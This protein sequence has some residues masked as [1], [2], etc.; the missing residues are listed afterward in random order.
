VP[1]APS[2]RV[3]VRLAVAAAA[4]GFAVPARAESQLRLSVP[5]AFGTVPAATYDT[6]RKRVGDAHLVLEQLEDRRVRIVAESGYDGGARNVATA[7]L[8]PAGAP[9]AFQP[10]LQ[11][12]RTFFGDGSLRSTLAVDHRARTATCGRAQGD[13]LQ[14]ERIE[15][16]PAD[17]VANVALS[18]L[19]EPLVRGDAGSLAFQLFL[20]EGGARVMDFEAHVERRAAGAHGPGSLVEVRYRPD[21]G[22]VASLVAEHLVPRLSFWFD[23]QAAQPWLAHR[24]PLYSKGPEVMVVRDGIPTR[25]LVDGN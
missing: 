7:L 17:R 6:S 21:L 24:L 25:W 23:P 2:R 15:L 22:A 4:L 10:V 8:E 5:E 18:L 20:C 19:F 16:P 1:A 12:S 13:T 11:E 14:L 9:N 3:A